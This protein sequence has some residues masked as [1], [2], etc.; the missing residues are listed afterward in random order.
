L[1]P[2]PYERTVPVPVKIVNGVPRPFYGGAWPLLEEGPIGDLVLPAYAFKN[3]RDAT[4]LSVPLIIPI[5]RI[6]A[7]IS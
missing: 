3:P 7:K 2:D 1:I 5:L 4:L 6:C